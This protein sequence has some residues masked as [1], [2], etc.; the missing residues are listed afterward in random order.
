MRSKLG[1]MT[2]KFSLW[3]DLTVTENLDIM[4]RIFGLS[5]HERAARIAEL[6]QEFDLERIAKQRAG[7][8]SGGQKQRLALAA[9]T[10]HRPE[11]LLLD[12][13]TSG[14][15]PQA[16]AALEA[17]LGE[18]RASGHG[19][20]FSTHDVPRATLLAT[21]VVMLHR[22]RMDWSGPSDGETAGVAIASR[23]DALFATVRRA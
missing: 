5:K 13:P 7:T 19:I 10:L 6:R 8:L 11:L 15:D 4:A 22:G 18:L 23:F 17:L 2:Q 21:R 12:E 1:Y 9:A 14:L 3:E 20:V 16:T